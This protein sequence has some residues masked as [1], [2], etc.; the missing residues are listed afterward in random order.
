[1]YHMDPIQESPAPFLGGHP[2]VIILG[3]IPPCKWKTCFLELIRSVCF[4]ENTYN[5]CYP[6]KWFKHGNYCDFD[7]HS[8]LESARILNSL[9]GVSKSSAL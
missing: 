5:R 8:F 6:H 4:E 9:I 1:M 3:V 7:E 2:T